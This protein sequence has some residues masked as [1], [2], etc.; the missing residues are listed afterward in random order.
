MITWQCALQKLYKL[1]PQDH[2]LLELL[3]LTEEVAVDGL[4]LP[5]SLRE[6]SSAL[7]EGLGDGR[8]SSKFVADLRQTA[9]QRA[10]GTQARK[11]KLV[12]LEKDY[13]KAS[14]LSPKLVRRVC[15]AAAAQEAF[16]AE[17][18]RAQLWMTSKSAAVLKSMC[19]GSARYNFHAILCSESEA[20]EGCG[21]LNAKTKEHCDELCENH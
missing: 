19:A 17:D 7:P 20:E 18:A 2:K 10:K 21:L 9:N 16:K 15:L 14:S 5:A 6:I 13:G 4:D 1:Y 11:K 8:V 3:V 12:A